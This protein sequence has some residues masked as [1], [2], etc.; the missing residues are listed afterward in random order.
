MKADI[1]GCGEIWPMLSGVS[2]VCGVRG[3]IT[4]CRVYVRTCKKNLNKIHFTL[5]LP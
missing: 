5:T 1:P 2:G 4:D 3:G